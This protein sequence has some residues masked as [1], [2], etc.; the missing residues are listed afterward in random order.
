VFD[1]GYIMSKT[2]KADQSWHLFVIF[3]RQIRKHSTNRTHR[4]PLPK[5]HPT[6]L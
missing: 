1:S 2:A 6:G 5:Y 3:L 4:H